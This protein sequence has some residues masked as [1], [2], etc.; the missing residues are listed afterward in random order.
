[1]GGIFNMEGPLFRFGNVVADIMILSL[2]WT[3]FSIPIFT[4]GASTTALF[5][6]TTRRLSDKEG[7]LMRDFLSSFKANFKQAT[8]IWLAWLGLA[9][10]ISANLRLLQ[11]NEFDSTLFMILLPIQLVLM[12]E[13]FMMSIYLYPLTARFE[14]SFLQT[15]KSAFFMANRHLL[16]TISCAAIVVAI[17]L[18]SI[19]IF[20]PIILVGIGIYA[21]AASYML[22]IIFKKYRPEIDADSV[23]TDQLEPIRDISEVREDAT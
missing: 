23:A 2:I 5:Y 14:M 15:I 8:L 9:L 16:T 17:F 12:L 21:Y 7:Y 13:L 3:I 6:V 19:Y 11:S 1:M 4:I 10:L 18:F 22:M 20:F